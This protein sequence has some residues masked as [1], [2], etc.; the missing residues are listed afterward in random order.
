MNRRYYTHHIGS[1]V[2][3]GEWVCLVGGAYHVLRVASGHD[4]RLDHE[5]KF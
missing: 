1:N 4:T 2:S 5:A 3:D